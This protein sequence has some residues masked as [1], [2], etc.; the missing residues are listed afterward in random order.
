[1]LRVRMRFHV[2]EVHNLRAAIFWG[3]KYLQLVD[4]GSRLCPTACPSRAPKS[5]RENWIGLRLR[6]RVRLTLFHSR[7]TD[8]HKKMYDSDI[9]IICNNEVFQKRRAQHCTGMN[10]QAPVLTRDQARGEHADNIKKAE[11][12]RVIHKK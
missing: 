7:P 2:M 6:L 12:S 1:M 4:M 5:S 8:N 10:S 3:G 9:D 11:S